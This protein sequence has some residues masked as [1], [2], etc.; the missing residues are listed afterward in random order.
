M[1]DAAELV[2]NGGKLSGWKAVEV[3]QSLDTI[4]GHFALVAAGPEAWPIPEGADCEV[5]LGGE[6]V[7]TGN[8]DRLAVEWGPGE[9]DVRCEGRDRTADLVDCSAVD[10]PAEFLDI[11][12]DV[13]VA[14]IAGAYGIELVVGPGVDI[15][16]PFARFAIQPSETAFEAIDRATRLRA[17]LATSDGLGRL[18]FIRPGLDRAEVALVGSEFGGNVFQGSLDYDQ[19]ARYRRYIVEGTRPGSDLVFADECV[20]LD[21]VAHDLAIRAPRTLKIKAEGSVDLEVAQ[22]RATWEAVVRAA[23]SSYVTARVPGWRQHPGGALWRPGLTVSCRLPKLRTEGDRIIAGV[24]FVKSAR[25]QYTLLV[26][27]RVNAYLLQPD[28]TG[29]K[30]EPAF[31]S[32]LGDGSEEIDEDEEPEEEEPEPDEGDSP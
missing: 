28:V 30:G 17:V 18:L 20:E 21:G 5:R 24:R 31:G 32:D 1:G 7:I 12:L 25:G 8:L 23:R 27:A 19:T 26:L 2:V 13:L 3:E 29:K 6:T 11:E 15:G 9:H 22:R 14:Q 4:A 16:A 10:L